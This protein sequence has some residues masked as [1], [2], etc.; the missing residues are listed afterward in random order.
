MMNK[1]IQK[2]TNY[3]PNYDLDRGELYLLAAEL[4]AKGDSAVEEIE[5]EL[6]VT[7]KNL[8]VVLDL[9][10]LIYLHL[11]AQR[12]FN[13]YDLNKR[14]ALLKDYSERLNWNQVENNGLII[15][16]DSARFKLIR[17]IKTKVEEALKTLNKDY[18]F[19]RDKFITLLD[20][21]SKLNK[22]RSILPEQ[23]T[24][25]IKVVNYKAEKQKFA[26]FRGFK[27]TFEFGDIPFSFS[28]RE[29]IDISDYKDVLST[30]K[31]PDI[32]FIPRD[33]GIPP[34]API[35]SNEEDDM[36]GDDYA[37]PRPTSDRG[38]LYPTSRPI[39]PP[40]IPASRPI[41][42][43]SDD[44]SD[45]GTDDVNQGRGFDLLGDEDDTF[46][47]ADSS[48]LWISSEPLPSVPTLKNWVELTSEEQ[49]KVQQLLQS[50]NLKLLHTE[51]LSVEF[52]DGK[53]SQIKIKNTGSV[54][55]NGTTFTPLESI[56]FSRNEVIYALNI[57]NFAEVSG[58]G[59]LSLKSPA[60]GDSIKLIVDG[61]SYKST[62]GEINVDTK[63]LKETELRTALGKL[64]PNPIVTL[65]DTPRLRYK[66]YGW[67][68]LNDL[69]NTSVYTLTTG[70]NIESPVVLNRL[71]PFS[72]VFGHLSLKGIGLIDFNDISWPA[73]T[74][75]QFQ[76]SCALELEKLQ[77]GNG[78]TAK[79]VNL[80]LSSDG[81]MYIR[82]SS[83]AKLDIH[84]SYA[85][86]VS[87]TSNIGD[88]KVN[89]HEV[90]FNA[91][92][93][94]FDFVNEFKHKVPLEIGIDGIE[95]KLAILNDRLSNFELESLNEIVMIKYGHRDAEI[96]LRIGKNGFDVFKEADGVLQS[97]SVYIPSKGV[98]TF[99]K[100]GSEHEYVLLGISRMN[101]SVL[102]NMYLTPYSLIS[103]GFFK[104]YFEY[105]TKNDFAAAEEKLSAED[106][107]AA[108]GIPL[109]GVPSNDED[110]NDDLF[111]G[112]PL[113]TGFDAPPS[114]EDNSAKPRTV[115]EISTKGLE[116][117][118][119][120][121]LAKLELEL[122]GDYAVTKETFKKRD[123][124]YLDLNFT[125]KFKY[126]GLDILTAD[127]M[128]VGFTTDA[129]GNEVLSYVR[130]N[131][132]RIFANGKTLQGAD[133][134]ISLKGCDI[135]F[136]QYSGSHIHLF[137]PKK[138]GA[139]IFTI[140]HSQGENGIDETGQYYKKDLVHVLPNIL[141]YWFSHKGMPVQ[142]YLTGMQK[143]GATLSNR[144]NINWDDADKG[145]F[146]QLDRENAIPIQLYLIPHDADSKLSAMNGKLNSNSYAEFSGVTLTKNSNTLTGIKLELKRQKNKKSTKRHSVNKTPKIRQV[147]YIFTRGDSSI[148]FT[149]INAQL[150][151]VKFG[152]TLLNIRQGESI[153]DLIM[154]KLG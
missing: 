146:S 99:Q 69:S 81:K 91:E 113:Y 40:P 13:Q 80:L 66:V 44:E 117:Q 123:G 147:E 144:R 1:L 70:E 3:D 30:D 133:I 141:S 54:E 19:D 118:F 55:H 153:W 145:H 127:T 129:A 100:V 49:T 31:E 116:A 138:L 122:I 33:R 35:P 53:L 58:I 112:A 56:I 106:V 64:I 22:I 9:M 39:P 25:P 110:E 34:L 12:F 74:E 23:A 45:P 68:A 93:S 87:I 124:F 125:A 114:V 11:D 61:E 134:T 115:D 42:L 103:F 101:Y 76:Y 82:Q 84:S 77:L 107:E 142:M 92:T 10:A 128:D 59:I 143:L 29:E 139:N 135:I 96:T 148:Q 150:N 48:N 79:N 140:Y 119:Q 46:G 36:W 28:S 73:D 63:N 75:D 121:L 72:F 41:A 108:L 151:T 8:M 21:L 98:Y 2:N 90:V 67:T 132:A 24:E 131:N 43:P 37:T 97:R 85:N 102:D 78:L 32:D 60:A 71:L 20:V 6:E 62:S 137:N 4:T 57:A 95:N 18:K 136:P 104:E 65:L 52:L 120:E 130:L 5:S 15:Q 47:D 26:L 14:A 149:F 50:N 17:A 111:A 154:Q 16:I 94:E 38:K 152:R 126:F 88:G 109:V 89:I 51:I 27:H 83:G 7:P 86:G 105:L